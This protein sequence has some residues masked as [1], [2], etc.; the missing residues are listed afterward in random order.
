[1]PRGKPNKLP[2][3]QLE[4]LRLMATGLKQREAAALMGIRATTVRD[5]LH[6]AC[7]FLGAI[8]TTHAVA[9]GIQR[10]ELKC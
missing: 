9:L 2:P 4:A 10:G 7:D 6:A 3:R 5:H 1:M 8:N